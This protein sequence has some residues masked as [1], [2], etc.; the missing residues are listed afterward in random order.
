MAIGLD[1]REK[2]FTDEGRDTDDA[3]SKIAENNRD[4]DRDTLSSLEENP[5][6]E[7]ADTPNLMGYLKKEGLLTSKP[8]TNIVKGLFNKQKTKLIGGGIGIV[9]IAG[10]F[11]IALPQKLIGIMEM[12]NINPTAL[13]VDGYIEH[14][15][16]KAVLSAIMDRLGVKDPSRSVVKSSSLIG[17]ISKTM[18]AVKYEERLANQGIEFFKDGDVMKVRLTKTATGELGDL[19][20]KAFSNSDDLLKALDGTPLTKKIMK[21]IIRK[22]LGIKGFFMRGSMTKWMKGYLGIKRWGANKPDKNAT[23]DQKVAQAAS[24]DVAKMTDDALKA[25]EMST[26][27][28]SNGVKASDPDLKSD[29]ATAERDLGKVAKEVADEVPIPKTAAGASRGVRTAAAE[30]GDKFANKIVA[31]AVTKGSTKFLGIY[32][33]ISFGADVLIFTD[34]VTKNLANGNVSRI[35]ATP[36][37]YIMMSSYAKYAGLASQNKLDELDHDLYDYYIPF[38]DGVETSSLFNCA[39]TN[40]VSA[41]ETRGD[42]I[43]KKVNE[44]SSTALQNF[45]NIMYQSQSLLGNLSG[46][47]PAAKALKTVENSILGI[48]VDAL[49][50]LLSDTTK[51]MSTV[52][53]GL[54]DTAENALEFIAGFGAK[55]L[56]KAFGLEINPLMGGSK[57]FDILFNGSVYSLN[58]YQEKALGLGRISNEENAFQTQKYLAEEREYINSQGWAYAL[59]SPEVTSS[60]TSRFIARSNTGSNSSPFSAV[61]ASMFGVVR[62]TPSSLAN[63]AFSHTSASSTVTPESLLGIIP[64]G[65]TASEL[66]SPLHSSLFE[67]G[68][69]PNQEKKGIMDKISDTASYISGEE[70]EY[71]FDNCYID[72]IAA[73]SIICS[74]DASA[75]ET[76]DCNPDA[77]SASSTSSTPGGS[78]AGSPDLENDSRIEYLGEETTIGGVNLKLYALND[79]T[80]TQDGYNFRGSNGRA[81]VDGSVATKFAD[82]I[83]AAKKDGIELKA[84]DSLRTFD[85]QNY[86]WNYYNQNPWLAAK[87]TGLSNHEVGIAI[88]FNTGGAPSPEASC[89]NRAS[90]T[91]AVYQWLRNNSYKYGIYQYSGE[92]WHFDTLTDGY[93][94]K[95]P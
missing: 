73:Q 46:M 54:A 71:V 58:Q 36:A 65:M 45:G 85:E 68:V 91:S 10:L 63:I 75:T 17:K 61:V 83:E 72:Q 64:F 78:Q 13:R 27:A 70:K 23:P 62:E 49:V 16:K 44:T 81:V 1:E 82:M 79:L 43:Y 53:P 32:G 55:I 19:A 4:L 9:T 39:S 40:W 26:K 6:N 48:A 37:A 51:F 18:T 42:E 35:V 24:D 92:P 47:L 77:G 60:V 95:T 56:I 66:D 76:P 2:T 94:C 50:G 38:F 34:W 5:V 25:L 28:T 52:F 69:C 84:N 33:L 20:N 86:W 8:K 21:D 59:F 41:C 11:G 14:R 30:F 57:L 67:E 3:F 29:G 7:E 89:M 22:D 31:S 74:I 15:A 12:I 87:P 90:S 80:D 93:R 88:D